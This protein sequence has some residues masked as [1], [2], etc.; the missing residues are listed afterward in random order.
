LPSFHCKH[1]TC[2]AVINAP[3][4]CV[5]HAAEASRVE[6]T[7]RQV[8]DQHGRD[9]DAKA[10]YNSSGWLRCRDNVLADTPVCQRCQQTF[11]Q[12][13]HHIKPLAEC[14]PEE[15]LAR[16]NLLA[17]CQP[18]HSAIEAGSV[19]AAN[20][21]QVRG[22][23]NLVE[24]QDYVFDA[25]A[26]E[27]PI[28]FIE[29]YCKHYEGAHAGKPFILH[30]V[31][32]KIVRDVYGWKRRATGFRRFNHLWMEAGVGAGKSPLMAALGLFGLMADG[33]PGAQVF[34]TALESSQAAVIY[35]TAK[36]FIEQSPELSKRL[37]VTQFCIS[38][39]KSRSTWKIAR[40]KPKAG[41][42][43]SVVLGD[44]VHEWPN[45][46]MY[47]SLQS[48]MG[49][50][51]QPL[52]IL[53]TNAAESRETFCWEMHQEAVA[54]L[55]RRNPHSTMYPVI[56]AADEKADMTDPAAWRDANPLIGVTI[57]LDKVR[58][59]CE[60]AQ[61]NPAL[62]AR[63]KRLYMTL[64]VQGAN[65]W[66]DLRRWDTCC[67]ADALKPEQLKELPLYIGVDLS[68]GDDLCAEV[69]VWVSPDRFYI[70][71]HFWL[72]GQTAQEYQEQNS[73]PYLRW[74]R[75]GAIEIIEET[76]INAAVKA[77]I[78]A[79]IAGRAQTAGK[80]KAIGY[81]RYKADEVIAALEALQI[82]CIPVAQGYTLSPGCVELNR[83]L[84]EGSIDIT[85]NPVLRMCAANVEVKCDERGNFWPVKPNQKGKY[86]GKRSAKIDG[87]T[88]LVTAL[89]EARKHS[90]P[91][92]EKKWQGGVYLI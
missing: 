22:M 35:E 7:R 44:E 27:R 20:A 53:G 49:K 14:E 91:K 32:K 76:T 79:A 69:D 86:A 25:V 70:D 88:A 84:K 62:T 87:I 16:E 6:A 9:Q 48:R 65:K 43:P 33:E 23:L 74:G 54:A 50:R 89:T 46:K 82:P 36:A 17:V 37:R 71:A 67:P 52:F 59:E 55:S 85:A 12:H 11:A 42:R 15:K 1:P 90:F 63:F 56:F 38:H 19:T 51:R 4:Y 81:D 29:R 13:V 77:R 68:Q 31:Q 57:A 83:R 3:G 40:G 66:L 2:S 21:P 60:R 26:G 92:S 30:D 78:A 41:M 58:E 18:C 47:D 64:W 10:F 8:Y 45:R 28:N 73:V 72:P 75:E 24:T 5:A 80:I 34:T 61:L 39:P